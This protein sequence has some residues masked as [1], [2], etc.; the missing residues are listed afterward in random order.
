MAYF[1]KLMDNIN[2]KIL[3]RS[4]RVQHILKYDNFESPI[5]GIAVFKN[6]DV[7]NDLRDSVLNFILINLEYAFPSVKFS[8]C[9][10]FLNKYYDFII[11]LPNKTP[12]GLLLF[13][14]ETQDAYNKMHKFFS[15]FALKFLNIENIKKIH[16]PIN[17]RISDGAAQKYD[18][19]PRA[20][21][22]WH[23][24]IWAGEPVQSFLMF[25]PILGSCKA[26]TVRYVHGEISEKSMLQEQNDYLN[27]P[28]KLDKEDFYDLEDNTFVVTDSLVFHQTVR[29]KNQIRVSI[30][31]RGIYK[32]Q[33]N[34]EEN[35][36]E[37]R[38]KNYFVPNVW[39]SI[40]TKL[41]LTT[42]FSFSNIDERLKNDNINKVKTSYPLDFKLI[43][44]E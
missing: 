7:V 22:K 29:L 9:E 14:R 5:P 1:K 20:S 30:D 44:L 4:K 3:D 43:N 8:I 36:F 40:N 42:D 39:S 10:D 38:Q 16:I 32:Q 24:D 15:K 41:D 11:N 21:S 33:F 35:N 28:V 2:F 19:R 13:Q 25:M 6:I 31:C 12:N 26:S 27:M 17:C 18:T 34:Y 23:I 37:L